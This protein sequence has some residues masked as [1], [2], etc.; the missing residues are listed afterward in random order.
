MDII[1]HAAYGATLCSRSGL[2]GG[3]QGARGQRWSTD[4]TV[5]AAIGFSL[6]PDLT[7]I[8]L[9]FAEMMVRGG[10]PSF[11]GI[12]PYVMVL[13]RLTH[14]LLV[15]GLIVGLCRVLYRP[16]AIPALECR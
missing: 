14:N 13:Y 8:G 16:L 7:S 15:A 4:W 1:G 3:R 2:A 9:S 10:H 5:W 11:H 6:L 12:P